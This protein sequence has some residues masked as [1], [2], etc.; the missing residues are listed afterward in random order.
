MSGTLLTTGVAAVRHAKRRRKRGRILQGGKAP[1]SPKQLAQHARL[2][3]DGRPMSGKSGPYVYYMFKGRQ[4]WRRDVPNR[5]PRTFTQLRSRAVF[6]AASRVWSQGGTLTQEQRAA[7]HAEGAKTRSRPRLGQS[8]PLTG[9][10]RFVG[11]NST[12]AQR[13]LGL[14]LV[15]GQRKSRKPQLKRL[16]PLAV[17]APHRRP[18]RRG[19]HR[20]TKPSFLTAQPA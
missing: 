2:L 10:Q 15:P 14:L 6:G 11:R 18:V 13:Q 7:W 16:Q 8:G 17:P 12:K 19:Y 1:L 9:Q 4:R 20:K 5:D 3:K